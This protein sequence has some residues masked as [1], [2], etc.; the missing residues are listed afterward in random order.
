VESDHKQKH[1]TH[2]RILPYIEK[3]YIFHCHQVYDKVYEIIT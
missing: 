2:T 1:N 3:H